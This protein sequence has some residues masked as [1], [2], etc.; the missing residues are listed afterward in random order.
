MKRKFG[1]D[2]KVLWHAKKCWGAV[3]WTFTHYYIVEK[4]GE[5]TKLICTKGFLNITEEELHLYRITDCTF[6]RT[7][8]NLFFGTGTIYV[9]ADE[10]QT[11]TEE[12]IKNVRKSQVAK[13]FLMDLVEKERK[14]RNIRTSEVH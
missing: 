11:K 9:H 1:E 12:I 5:W 2:I 6:K 10:G 4:P 13:D 8:G 14:T 7:F 3:P